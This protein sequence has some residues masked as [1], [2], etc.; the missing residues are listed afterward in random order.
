[1]EE[2]EATG[3]TTSQESFEF[4]EELKPNQ[5]HFIIL[6]LNLKSFRGEQSWI[7]IIQENINK[8]QQQKLKCVTKHDNNILF[9]NRDLSKSLDIKCLDCFVL[10]IYQTFLSSDTISSS[11]KASAVSFDSCDCFKTFSILRNILKSAS[12]DQWVCFWLCHGKTHLFITDEKTSIPVED[13]NQLEIL[14]GQLIKLNNDV[15]S[16]LNT[17]VPLGETENDV[18]TVITSH[19]TNQEEFFKEMNEIVYQKRKILKNVNTLVHKHCGTA[20]DG[21]DS[22][23]SAFRTITTNNNESGGSIPLRTLLQCIVVRLT[24]SNWTELRRYVARNIPL[25]VLGNIANNIDFFQELENRSMIQ[26]RNTEYI[27]NGFYEIGRVDLVH[28]LDCIQEGDYSLLSLDTVRNRSD[29]NN[30]GS[31]TQP[32]VRQMRDLTLDT[33]R[34]DSIVDQRS[35]WSSSAAQTQS[36]SSQVREVIMTDGLIARSPRNMTG[37]SDARIDRPLQRRYRNVSQRTTPSTPYPVQEQIEEGTR[38]QEQTPENVLNNEEDTSAETINTDDVSIQSTNSDGL[39]PWSTNSE[40]TSPQGQ[41]TEDTPSSGENEQDTPPQGANAQGS[42]LQ[43]RSEDDTFPEGENVEET[44]A[45][46]MKRQYACEHYDRYCNAQFACC[47][48]FWPCHRC[49]NATS[50]C[51]ER[52]LRSRDIKKLQCCRCGKVQGFP[53]E[54]PNCVECNLKFAEYFC[55]MCHHLTGKQNHPFH[56]EKCGICRM[57]C[58]ICREIFPHTMEKGKKS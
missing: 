47:E 40:G 44:R 18:K 6:P 13:F 56:C 17:R 50:Q 8:L 27:R 3:T 43:G 49:H 39:T 48:H 45:W 42:L 23:G 24:P 57:Q 51:G 41:N 25:R 32:Y 11:G 34:N 21:K 28:L 9:V 31:R 15:A 38:N 14:V 30:L 52:K 36:S 58:P 2:N 19:I 16:I 29:D 26:I 54:S 53:K 22:P 20:D 4:A 1:M 46:M 10:S 7:I 12:T 5:C 33:R 37:N 55:P 35:L